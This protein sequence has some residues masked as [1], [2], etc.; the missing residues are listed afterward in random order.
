MTNEEFQS[1][2]VHELKEMKGQ[3][4]E[5]KG[6]LK[7]MKSQLN[8]NTQLLRALEHK[9]DVNKSEHDKIFFDV[10]ELSSEVKKG[11][12]DLTEINKSLMEMYG[13]HEAEIRTLRRKTV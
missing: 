10:A 9:A 5:M 2:V 11:F 1:L 8:E 12:I 6:Q 7:E 3:L 13:S 4:K